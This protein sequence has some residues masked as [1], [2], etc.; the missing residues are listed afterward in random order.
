VDLTIFQPFDS[1]PWKKSAREIRLS[2][3]IAHKRFKSKK[4]ILGTI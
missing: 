2:L 3:F 1:L 4:L